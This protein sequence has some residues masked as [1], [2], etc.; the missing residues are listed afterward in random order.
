[1]QALHYLVAIRDPAQTSPLAP[2]KPF[3]I[4]LLPLLGD[5]DPTVRSLALSSTITIF[6]ASGVSQPAK[7][8]L[9]KAMIKLDVGKKVQDSIL[10]AVLGGAGPLERTGSTTSASDKGSSALDAQGA[11]SQIDQS[12]PLPRS[13]PRPPSPSALAAN[14]P[15][16]A[17]PTDPSAIHAPTTDVQPVYIADTRDLQLEFERMKP[18]FEGK[19]SEH[20]WMIRDKS[21]AR[22]RGMVKGGVA[23]KFLE[24][25]MAG[26]KSVQEGILKTVSQ[27]HHG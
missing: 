11:S 8:D 2:L 6:S 23:D 3:T 15:S 21:I 16:T 17:F 9:K 26:L 14:L 1:M 24:P 22:I 18:G 12:P 5:P 19:E 27:A 7:A 4:L 25:F 10:A 13:R 20:N